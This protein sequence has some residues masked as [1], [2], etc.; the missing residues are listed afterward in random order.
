[1][2][3]VMQIQNKQDSIIKLMIERPKVFSDENIENFPNNRQFLQNTAQEQIELTNQLI[4]LDKEQ[5]SKLKEIETLPI[6]KNFLEYSKLN[7]Q[8]FEKRLE[9][10]LISI[11]E[12]QLI[13][14]DT[15]TSK[16]QLKDFFSKLKQ[17]EAEIDLAIEQLEN[18]Q[19]SIRK[20]TDR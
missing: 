2:S 8:I 12:Y 3:E 15:L 18:Q 13:F 14:D 4:Q 9:S 20:T 6:D 10:K 11:Q 7:R 19:K 17:E 1:M 5:I 16:Q